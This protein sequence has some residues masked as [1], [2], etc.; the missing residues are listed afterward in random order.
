MPARHCSWCS[1]GP[2]PRKLRENALKAVVRTRSFA[3]SGVYGSSTGMKIDSH[4]NKPGK[5]AAGI[6]HS[7]SREGDRWARSGVP[8]DTSPVGTGDRQIEAVRISRER[9]AFHKLVMHPARA[10]L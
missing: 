4:G 8:L 9:G 10:F 7:K 2:D 3:Y 1:G 6:R 5:I